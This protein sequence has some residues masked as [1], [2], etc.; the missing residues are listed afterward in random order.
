[1]ICQT[2]SDC[3]RLFIFPRPFPRLCECRFPECFRLHRVILAGG[4]GL[5]GAYLYKSAAVSVSSG[6][7]MKLFLFY[8][9]NIYIHIKNYELVV[10]YLVTVDKLVGV[11][12]MKLLKGRKWRSL[13]SELA[14]MQHACHPLRVLVVR[15]RRPRN[16]IFHTRSSPSDK[17][18]SRTRSRLPEVPEDC[19]VRG[20]ALRS[21]QVPARGE[22]AVIVYKTCS[23]MRPTTSP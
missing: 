8:L 16:F 19:P 10:C 3:S 23:G 17:E 15:E 6:P 1:M 13:G 14:E 11:Y 22:K 20:F 7:Q 4:L 12:M 2:Y 18:K 21:R 5:E 9:A